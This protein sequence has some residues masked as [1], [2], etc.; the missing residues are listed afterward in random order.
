MQKP[1]D[2]AEW[3][4]GDIEDVK[5]SLPGGVGFGT[6]SASHKSALTLDLGLSLG[7]TESEDTVAAVVDA[8]ESA[9][10]Q[11][12]EAR[13]VA[14]YFGTATPHIGLTVKMDA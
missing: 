12:G 13:L 2:T 10:V 11:T 5:E 6:L 1:T 4:D 9:G 14:G 3:T 7:A 8:L